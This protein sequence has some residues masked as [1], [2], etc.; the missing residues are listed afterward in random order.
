MQQC[1][2]YGLLLKPLQKLTKAVLTALAVKARQSLWSRL[3]V[4]KYSWQAGKAYNGRISGG[5]GSGAV[6]CGGSSLLGSGHLGLCGG[7]SPLG[8]HEA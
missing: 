2:L 5:R 1:C 4:R 3:I 6:S 8:S 7:S